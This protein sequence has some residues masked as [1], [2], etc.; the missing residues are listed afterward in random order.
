[1]Y[2]TACSKRAAQL[3][4]LEVP[5]A[6]SAETA[7]SVLGVLANFASSQAPSLG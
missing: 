2:R 7:V 6:A 3:Q 5:T 4:A 1:M